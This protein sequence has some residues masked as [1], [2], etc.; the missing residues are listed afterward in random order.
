MSKRDA[1]ITVEMNRLGG[2]VGDLQ[3]ENA[4][5]QAIVDGQEYICAKCGLRQDPKNRAEDPGF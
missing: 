3:R 2:L 5:L 4:R 1:Q